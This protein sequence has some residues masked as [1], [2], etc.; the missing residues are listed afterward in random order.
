MGISF[1]NL[2]EN[3]RTVTID[4][5]GN[6][7]HVTYKPKTLSPAFMNKLADEV[8]DDDP[9]GFSKMFC[10]VVT[11]W[12]LEG[13]LG[14]GENAIKA[15][16]AVPLDLEVVSWIPTAL[17]RYILEQIAEDSAPKGRKRSNSSRR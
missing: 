15:G 3:E 1:T 12:D 4:V 13:P 17:M 7:L 10:S 16:E 6:D 8:E 2:V 5:N 14:E 9:E 11:G